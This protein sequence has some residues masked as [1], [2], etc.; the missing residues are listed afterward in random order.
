MNPVS[1]LSHHVAR[2]RRLM[3]L[4]GDGV[5]I[6]PTAP[7]QIRNG[8]AHYPYRADSYFHYLTGFD[9]P[10]AILVMVVQSGRLFTLLF[11]RERNPLRELWDG[12]RVGV[13]RAPAVLGVDEALPISRFDEMLPELLS[14]Q[15]QLLSL[16]GSSPAWDQR[17]LNG[18]NEVR[19]RVRSGANAPLQFNEIRQHLDEMR[20]IK[21]A[22]EVRL[23]KQAGR[24]TAGAHQRLMRAVRPGA[25]EYEME[26]ELLHEFRRQGADG[27]AY[28]SIVAGGANACVLHYVKNTDA[29]QDGDLLLVDAGCEYQGYASD[30]T[31]TFPV[32]GRFSGPQRD[33]Y[34]IVWE[35]QQAALKMVRP[36][37]RFEQYHQAAV[38]VLAQGLVDVGLCKGSVD[39]VIESGDYQRFYM[40]RTGHWLGRD[41]HDVGS[42]TVNE[43]SRTLQ[44]GM[45]VTVEPGLYV[46]KGR[47][48]PAH[49]ANIGIRIEDDALVSATG[50]EVITARVPSKMDE[51]EA[52]M[53]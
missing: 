49:F 50:H 15:E 24:I 9:E 29:L 5:A 3:R 21:D 33:L 13:E 46:A 48:V 39:G 32:N 36:G 42:Y 12:H 7:E 26:A 34:Q 45:V 17:L 47:G 20:L 10:E 22:G 53:A 25:F 44:P 38:K 37:R 11:C 51:I 6:I 8:D 30:I 35:A 19:R 16:W 4:M 1:Q 23:M 2:R 18:V 31:R 41:V 28:T 52:W 43:K 40:H 14:G 27:P